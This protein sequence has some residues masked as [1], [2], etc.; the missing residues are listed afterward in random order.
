MTT[1]TPSIENS[2][3]AE[4]SQLLQQHAPS[5][6]RYIL[7]RTPDS[8]IANEI[9]QDVFVHTIETYRCQT[10]QFP[11]AFMYNWHNATSPIFIVGNASKRNINVCWW[12]L[13][14]SGI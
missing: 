10:L 4:E 13:S 12:S 3:L 6:F 5:L 8:D 2:D 9:L 1:H 14:Q 7:A 11:R